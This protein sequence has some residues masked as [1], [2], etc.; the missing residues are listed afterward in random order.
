MFKHIAA[1]IL[2][3]G[4]IA[5]LQANAGLFGDDEARRAILDVREKVETKADKASVLDLAQQNQMLQEEVA[6][7]RGQVEVLTNALEMNVQR[8]KDFY[9]ELDE[10]LKKLEPTTRIV[11]GQEINVERAEQQRYDAAMNAFKQGKYPEAEKA[12]SSFLQQYPTSSYAAS[13]QH[14]LGNAYFAQKGCV[15]AIKAQKVVVDRYAESPEAP[16]AMLNMATCYV[17]QKKTWSAKKTL[18]ELIKRYPD[19]PAAQTAQ[20]R[21]KTL[22]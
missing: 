20:A 17:L 8:Q 6:K 4:A 19:A 10:R 7:L 13:A 1:V 22:K 2:F 5:P 11:N 18:K 16:N 15:N 3:A 14:G 21:L 12:F 9:V